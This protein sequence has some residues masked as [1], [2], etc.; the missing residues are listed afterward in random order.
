MSDVRDYSRCPA[1]LA[2][3]DEAGRAIIRL[4]GEWEQFAGEEAQKAQDADVFEDAMLSQLQAVLLGM[5]D[6]IKPSDLPS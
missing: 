4:W 5:L 2:A 1:I 3:A 6:R